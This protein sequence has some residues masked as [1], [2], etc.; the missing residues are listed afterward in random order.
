[1]QQEQLRQIE[2]RIVNTLSYSVFYDN[3]EKTEYFVNSENKESL[4]LSFSFVTTAMINDINEE[5]GSDIHTFFP[6]DNRI[7][8][9]VHLEKVETN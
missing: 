2:D 5:L 7:N 1:M 9:Y 4:I 3:L 8:V 6:M